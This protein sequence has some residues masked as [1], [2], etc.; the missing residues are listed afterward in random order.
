M[1]MVTLRYNVHKNLLRIM[2][3]FFV[4]DDSQYCR[5]GPVSSDIRALASRAGS[6]HD[7]LV[8]S[9]QIVKYLSGL[10]RQDKVKTFPSFLIKII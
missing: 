9:S 10:S 6:D 1:N 2:L 4:S 8:V 7:I 5:E 3:F